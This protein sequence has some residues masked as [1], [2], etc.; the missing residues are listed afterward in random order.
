[1][2]VCVCVQS[3][4]VYYQLLLTQGTTRQS[5]TQ[6]D[7]SEWVV[8]S[9]SSGAT[10]NL[11]N[12][13]ESTWYQDWSGGK[14]GDNAGV[15]TVRVVRLSESLV[16]V[17]LA[18]TKHPRRRLEQHIVMTTGVRGVYTYTAMTVVADGE[19][20]NEIRHNTRWDR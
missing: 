4:T 3:V 16:E 12:T 17:V 9:P 7:M 14:N 19:A 5:L 6:V 13:T 20:L 10:F 1:V 8:S 2:C 11:A 18:D 15:D